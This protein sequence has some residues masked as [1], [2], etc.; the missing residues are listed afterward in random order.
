MPWKGVTAREQKENFIRDYRL[1]Y[2]EISELCQ[3]SR[4][5]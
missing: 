2:Y 1:G 5:T 4:V 3:L